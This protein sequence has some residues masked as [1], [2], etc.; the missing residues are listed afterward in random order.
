MSD[1]VF[2]KITK[3]EIKGAT[4][5]EDKNTLAFL[6]IRPAGKNGGHTLVIPKNHY[7]KI[8]DMPDKELAA[9]A[10]TV[11]KISAALMKF[12]EGVNVIQNN[13]KVSGQYVMHAHFHVIPRYT[14]DGIKIEQWTPH[15]YAPGEIE[16]MQEKIKT[17]LKD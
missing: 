10:I 2:C 5:Y 13:G 9:L 12:S 16:E 3:G 1:C 17:L 7:E 4:V 8:T 11:K 15:D 6:D 14:G